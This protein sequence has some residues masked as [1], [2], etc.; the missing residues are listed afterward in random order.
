MTDDTTLHRQVNTSW[1]Q[2][3]RPSSQT[4]RP[5]PKDQFLLSL[6]DGDRI[7]AEA[8][9]KHFISAGNNSVGVLSLLVR[10][11]VAEELTCHSSPEVFAEHAHADYT[12]FTEG[13]MRGIGKRLLVVALNRGWQYQVQS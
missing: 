11:F 4:F 5:T 2:N 12:G 8:S 9:W 6:Y 7:D 10:E 1:I 13:Q 3:G